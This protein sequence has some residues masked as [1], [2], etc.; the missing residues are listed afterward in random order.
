MSEC[1]SHWTLEAQ[2]CPSKAAGPEGLPPGN[3]M[4]HLDLEQHCRNECGYAS[5]GCTFLS[6]KSASLAL[7]Y[8]FM[9]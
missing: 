7:L 9:P 3:Y 5:Q 2:E 4:K 6:G 8:S 1:F